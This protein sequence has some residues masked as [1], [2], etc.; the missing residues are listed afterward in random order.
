MFGTDYDFLNGLEEDNP[1]RASFEITLKDISKSNVVSDELSKIID[2]SWVKNNQDF[3]S[4]IMDITSGLK[5]GSFV[6]MIVFAIILIFIISN[7]IKISVSA[8]KDDIYTMRY[9]GATNDYIAIP[10]V[11]EGVII[12]LLGALVG[13]ICVIIG[14][15]YCSHMVGGYVENIVQI[16]KTHQIFLRLFVSC[17]LFGLFIG[18]SGSVYSVK[19]YIKA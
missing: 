2:V 15:A 6:L 12:G 17:M 3:V 1:L 16:Y 9:V 10:F 19:K 8:R 11:I 7:T 5:N 4:K 14:Y 18:A 13:F